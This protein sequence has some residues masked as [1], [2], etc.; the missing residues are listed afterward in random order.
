MTAASSALGTRTAGGPRRGEQAPAWLALILVATGAFAA[1][2]SARAVLAAA[3]SPGTAASSQTTAVAPTAGGPT[4]VPSTTALRA[5]SPLATSPLAPGPSTTGP[6]AAP[7]APVSSTVPTNCP[8]LFLVSFPDA[9]VEPAE[10][11][12]DQR[13][14]ALAA[15]LTAH[16]DVQ[17]VLDGHADA[18]GDEAANLALSAERARAV[19][20]RLT[21]AGVAADRLQTRGFGAYQPILGVDSG[22][23]RNRRVTMRVLGLDGCPTPDEAQN[24]DEGS[25]G[26]R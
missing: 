25:E 19:A 16:P 21:A 9:S 14:A 17:L 26:T 6:V 10:T 3:E 22:S 13:V 18:T 5:T 24:P 7:G 23:A 11:D 8:P 15:W 2:G 12:V 1:A 20:A 4:A